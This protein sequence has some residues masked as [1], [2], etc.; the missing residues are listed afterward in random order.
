M[1]RP[2]WFVRDSVLRLMARAPTFVETQL[3]RRRWAAWRLA[4]RRARS[5]RPRPRHD[6]E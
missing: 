2:I 3:I 4:E 1:Q 6:P 5:E